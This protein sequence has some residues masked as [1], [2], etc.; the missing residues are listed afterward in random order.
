MDPGV[1][2]AIRL[3]PN[4]KR[5]IEEMVLGSESFRTLCGDLAEAE[6]A[7]RRWEKSGAPGHAARCVEYR[8]LIDGLEAELRRAISEREDR[9]GNRNRI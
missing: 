8:H 4:H 3:L 1:L 7:L 2:S 9:S 6:Q 5:T